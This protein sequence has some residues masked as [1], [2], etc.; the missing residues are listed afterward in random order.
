MLYQIREMQR[1]MLNPFSDWANATAKLYSNAHSPMAHLPYAKSLFASFELM[2]RLGK[3]YEKPQWGL[4][5]TQIAGEEVDVVERIA[6]SKPFCKLIHFDR[7]PRTE[8]KANQAP[9]ARSRAKPSAQQ[10]TVLL[11]APLSGHHATL[12]RDTVRALLP[13]Y[14]VYVTDWVDARQVPLSVGAFSLDDY[15]A[16]CIEFMRHLGSETHVISVCQPTVP[17]M[18]AVSILSTLKDPAVPRSLTMMGGPIDTRKNPTAVNNLATTH[19]YEWFERNLIHTV[20]NKYAGAGRRVYPGFL[21]H[22]GFVAM[23]PDRHFKSHVDYFRDLRRG[24]SEDAQS[25]RQF[26]DEY[27]AVLDLPAEY[28]LQTIRTIFQEQRLAQGT[29][30]VWVDGKMI[31]VNPADIRKPRLLTVEGELDDISGSGQTQAAIELC[32]GIPTKRKQHLE[33]NGAGH[34]GIFSG[35]RWRAI[36]VPEIAKHIAAAG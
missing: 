12:L 25:H 24:D 11:F 15:V 23:N 4:D 29:W 33:V 28:Y 36:V 8:S 34:Y 9:K 7:R 10:P 16:Y 19:N 18:A 20:P 21:Q 22:T 31:R 2:H 35:K 1:A 27:N 32:A 3:E 30:D 5:I 6:L 14:E 13:D 26:Y 17:V